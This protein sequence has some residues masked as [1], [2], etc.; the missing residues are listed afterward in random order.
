MSEGELAGDV[1]LKLEVGDKGHVSATWW[2]EGVPYPTRGDRIP[3]PQDQPIAWPGG[4]HDL[5]RAL[6]EVLDHYAEW[7]EPRQRPAVDATEAA[8][9]AWGK[10][11]GD[12]LVPKDQAPFWQDLI[13][14]KL[15]VKLDAS[16]SR[17]GCAG[18]E[19]DKRVRD[20]LDVLGWPW[21]AVML[22]SASQELGLLTALVREHPDG[23]TR[24]ASRPLE[25]PL[26]VLLVSPRPAGDVVPWRAVSEPLTR[27]IAGQA[28]P[29][30]KLRLLRPPTSDALR[31]A[32]REWR[33]HVV[34][35]DAHGLD[36]AR[37]G[38][39]ALERPN[40]SLD[41]RY[42]AD[43]NS[44]L[45]QGQVPVVVLNACRAGGDGGDAGPQEAVWARLL[46]GSVHT[47]VAMP[48]A[49]HVDAAARF[50]PARAARDAL[51]ADRSRVVPGGWTVELDD[52]L[53]P[54]VM[55]LKAPDE[56]K[57]KAGMHAAETRQVADWL[58][59]RP[60]RRMERGLLGEL[61]LSLVHGPKG[62]GKRT[63][64]REL[65]E[66]LPRVGYQGLVDR[67]DVSQT[68][69][70]LQLLRRM[71]MM[72]DQR[73]L[74]GDSATLCRAL[75]A[76]DATW[77]WEGLDRA[78][79]AGVDGDWEVIRALVKSLK[80]ARGSGPG[81]ERRHGHVLA[82][83]DDRSALPEDIQVYSCE[84]PPLTRT[85][86]LAY[87]RAVL[88]RGGRELLKQPTDEWMMHWL[89]PTE[90]WLAAVEAR[91]EELSRRLN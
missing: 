63:A 71:A 17:D 88:Q 48:W 7:G 45:Q 31:A 16:T 55:T 39:I 28:T 4:G 70:A 58:R 54:R 73:L 22:P 33:P 40:Q 80:E 10:A 53:N 83:V 1:V 78:A 61:P 77:V 27:W 91:A 84:F 43:I 34:H 12:A 5:P 90:G 11:V 3:R 59:D 29:L 50:A 67:V 64:A 21:E 68:T 8:L 89:R 87:A 65:L 69:S 24:G 46:G 79:W 60:M 51:R 47:V 20:A 41:R 81:G 35:I 30:L 26:R 57:G 32:L 44:D 6:D 56:P 15:R 86:T 36:D 42:G 13:D 18:P 76:V 75:A 9:K 52:G 2:W 66:W 72:L 62:A 38:S 85:E 82:V 23:V 74:V 49:V 14:G 19:H 25:L 37:G